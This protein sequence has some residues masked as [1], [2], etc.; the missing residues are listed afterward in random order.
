MKKIFIL[1]LFLGS[2]VVANLYAAGITFTFGNSTLSGSTY[3]FD[4][5]VQGSTSGT[6]LGDNL[7]Y[8]NYDANAF[9]SNV[10]GNGNVTVTKGTMLQGGSAPAFYYTIVNVTDNT[11]SRFSVTVEYNYPDYPEY[12]NDLPTS[13][14][15]LLHIVLNIADDSYTAGLSFEQPLMDGQEYESDNT[16]KYNPVVADD[17]DDAPLSPI[18]VDLVSFTAERS[19]E[20]VLLRWK[21]A[22]E[23]NQAG[24]NIFRRAADEEMFVK[25][26]DRIIFSDPANSATGAEYTYLDHPESEGE[27]FYKLQNVELDG[28]ATF[29]ETISVS[30]A[31][32]VAEQSTTPQRFELLPNYPNPFNPET[33]IEYTTPK[34]SDVRLAVYNLQGQRIKT[35]VN[36]L[37]NAGRHSVVWNGVDDSGHV[38][39]SGIYILRIKAGDYQSSRRITL[40]R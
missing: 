8:I 28:S 27:Y 6:K 5:M 11:S 9:G 2:A 29:S 40:L 22:S 31:T 33:R 24:F 23:I 15:Q 1:T 34:E 13:P 10:V 17:T 37:K 12:G 30:I 26:N 3:E 35:L 4:V 38:A 16:T 32:G 39:G 7:V 36:E 20:E 21:T 25:I 14:T 19:G 18:V